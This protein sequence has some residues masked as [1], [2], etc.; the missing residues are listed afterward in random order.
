MMT[1]GSTMNVYVGTYTN[2]GSEGIYVLRQNSASGELTHVHTAPGVVNPSFLALDPG[3]RH[4]YAVD[5]VLEID[6]HA[7]GAVSAFDVDGE[8]GALTFLNRQASHGTDPCHVTTDRF[9]RYVFVANYTSG[10]VAVL[11]IQADGSL[12]PASDVVQHHGSS[13]LPDR[14]LGP[15][16]HSINLDAAS[17]FAFVADLGLDKVLVYRVDLDRGKL[18]P[19]QPPGP[20][21]KP[22]SGPRHFD[23]HPSGRFAFVIN[24]ISST[25]TAYAFDSSAGTL[26]EIQTESTLPAGWTGENSTADVHV[27]PSGKFVYG[28]NRGHDSIV[29]FAIDERTG[30][31]SYV[32]NEWTRG[33]TPRNFAIDPA[34]TFLYA[35]NQDSDSIVTFQVDQSTGKLTPT[36][37]TLSIPMPV[38]LKFAALPV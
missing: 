21:T 36:G 15:H 19:N 4:L 14:Q 12:A 7:G 3:R 9:G 8:S 38:C 25:L 11:P 23:F 28:S 10:S 16:A 30:R 32:G 34:G 35:A 33:K 27:A 24:E 26:S 29:I 31:M 13:I 37:G 2:G 18:I 20:S 17:R 6:G 1:S 22:G 5:E